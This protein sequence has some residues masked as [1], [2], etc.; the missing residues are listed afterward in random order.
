MGSAFVGGLIAAGWHATLITIV[1]PSEERRHALATMFPGVVISAEIGPCSAGVIAVKPPLAAQT[2]A[3]LS[4]AGAKRVLSIAAGISVATL[5]E[6]AG[7][8][9]AVVRAMPNTPAL[10]GEGAAGICISARCTEDDMVWAE[11]ILGAVGTVVR[12]DEQL[13]D[14]LTA[15]SGSGPRLCIF[16]CRGND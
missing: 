1:E 8:G 16:V 4:Q 10:V 13:I 5:R 12:I 7:S 11:S 15:I 6:A 9:T 2:C 3:Q 14:A